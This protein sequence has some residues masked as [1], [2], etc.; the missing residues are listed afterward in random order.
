MKGDREAALCW[1][2]Q[3]ERCRRERIGRKIAAGI[4]CN[5]GFLG[6]S[7]GTGTDCAVSVCLFNTELVDVDLWRRGISWRW[8]IYEY[9]GSYQHV[10]LHSAAVLMLQTPHRDMLL[11][12]CTCQ[13]TSPWPDIKCVFLCYVIYGTIAVFDPN[14]D[15]YIIYSLTSTH[16]TDW[17]EF[18]CSGL[19]SKVFLAGGLSWAANCNASCSSWAMKICEQQL[20]KTVRRLADR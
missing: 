1:V 16:F 10:E 3:R 19:N 20:S 2:Y 6:F 11:L 7:W 13:S 18:S 9:V 12:Y 4:V 8:D 17:S 15:K 14:R 5:Q